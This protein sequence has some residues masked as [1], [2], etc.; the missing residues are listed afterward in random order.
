MDTTDTITLSPQTPFS[1]ALTCQKCGSHDPSVRQVIYPYVISI[2]ALTFRHEFHGRWCWKHRT[3]YLLLAV[4]ITGTIGLLG[5]PFGLIYAPVALYRMA[6]G[7]VM[8]KASNLKLLRSLAESYQQRGFLEDARRCIENSLMFV[9]DLWGRQQLQSYYVLP[10]MEQEPYSD[11]RPGSPFAAAWL[12]AAAILLSG[13]AGLASHY[14]D[15]LFDLPVGDTIA[16]LGLLLLWMPFA[17]I[18]LVLIF[19]LRNIQERILENHVYQNPILILGMALL[20]GI[21]A[22]YGFLEGRQ[23][24]NFFDILQKQPN[25]PSGLALWNML[26]AVFSRGALLE[27]P[28]ELS[29]LEFGNFVHHVLLAGVPVFFPAVLI[30]AAWPYG[31][32]EKLLSEVRQRVPGGWE[33]PLAQRVSGLAPFAGFLC[34]GGLLLCFPQQSVVDFLEARDHLR[35]GNEQMFQEKYDLAIPEYQAAVQLDPFFAPAYVELGWTYYQLDDY[36]Q[37]IAQY[38]RSFELDPNRSDAHYDLGKIY[39]HDHQLE[40]AAVEFEK[41]LQLDPD[42][43]HAYLGLGWVAYDQTNLE[44]AEANFHKVLEFNDKE[45]E[46]YV[47]LGYI[48]EDR[49]Q[50]DEEI[51][52]YQR[53]VE[54]DPESAEARML[55]GMAYYNKNELDQAVTTLKIVLNLDQEN[56]LARLYLTQAYIYTGHPDTA[57]DFSRE[58][59]KLFP[60]WAEAHAL[61]GYALIE[62]RQLDAAIVEIQSAVE[63]TEK[64]DS[65][66]RL[67][68]R[69][70]LNAERFTEAEEEAKQAIKDGQHPSDFYLYLAET[71]SS[72]EKYSL[73]LTACDQAAKAGARPADILLQQAHIYLEQDQSDLSFEQL[74]EVIRLEPKNQNAHYL[75]SLIYA[76]KD[77]FVSALDEVQQTIELDRYYYS[78]HLHLASIQLSLRRSDEAIRAAS[79]AASLSPYADIPHFYLGMAYLQAGQD[80]SA[81]LELQKFLDLYQDTP[82]KKGLKEDAE[83]AL[84]KLNP[85]L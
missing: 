72:Q 38:I 5:F 39:Y 28:Q 20:A 50:L 61:L 43:Y 24:G 62:T 67:I 10:K 7:N 29:R 57:V 25:L 23:I 16:I 6:R 69:A 48:Y 47:G 51:N 49:D 1:N 58:T 79:R 54:S 15:K 41:T 80:R 63:M 56:Q 36:Q 78:A 46:A 11:G 17:A 45:Y 2:F 32:W 70:W 26:G 35:L 83:K 44:K 31:R 4:L 34:L 75:M 53:A 84:K 74:Q 68:I 85:S 13:M 3:L 81:A 18:G 19:T 64:T 40:K 55:L 73:A 65:D 8:H 33:T 59:L 21:L 76:D 60:D 66:R 52:A 42:F 9:D 30:L 37:A 27:I 22:A 77:D 82:S 12:F 71:Y 14:A